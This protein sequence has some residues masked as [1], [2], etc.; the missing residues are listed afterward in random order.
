RDRLIELIGFTKPGSEDLIK[1]IPEG[2]A[3]LVRRTATEPQANHFGLT[4]ANIHVVVGRH[5]GSLPVG[6]YRTVVALY[7]AIVD[8]VL[9]MGTLVL[10]PREKQFV[11][12]F[13]LGEEQQRMAFAGKDV[14]TQQRMRY[15]DRAGTHR[16]LDLL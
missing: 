7:H 3:L 4:A 2:V 8:A 11:V 14:F 12:G 9:D 10:L 1:L 13:V 16:G 6:V 5:L 15:R